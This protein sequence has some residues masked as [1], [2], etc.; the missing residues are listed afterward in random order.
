[1]RYMKK[2]S[3]FFFL[4]SFSSLLYAQ[5]SPQSSTSD[6]L[7]TVRLNTLKYGTETEIANLVQTLKNEGVDY[8]D[9]EIIALVENTRNQKILGGAFAFFSEREKS[10]LE[11]RAARA[12]EERDDEKNETILAAIDY[13]GRVKAADAVPIL[14]KIIEGG[15]KRFVN[16]AIRAFGR[17]SGA[18]GRS[19]RSET[20]E[21]LIDFYQNRSPDDDSR[22]EIITAL[23][24]AGSTE[25]AEFLSGIAIDG[26]EKMTLRIAALESIAKIGDSAGL[27]AVLACVSAADANIRSAAVAALGP[28]S[29]PAA[30]EAILDAFRDSYYRTRIAAAQASRQRKLAAAVPYLKF[31][32]ERDEVPTVKEEAVRAL[33]SIADSES[34]RILESFFT[35]RKT[36]E[37]VRIVSGEMLMQIQPDRFLDSLVRE[38]DEAKQKNQNSLYN[39]ILKIIGGAKCSN[40]EAITRRLMETNGAVEKSTALDM[41][42]NNN[43]TSLAAEIKT[44][45]E[46]KSESLAAKARRTLEKLGVGN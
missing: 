23:G 18:E 35:E 43:L 4:F 7:E 39:G 8:L 22:R 11:S 6:S 28:F 14:Q 46:G 29:G 45:A 10:G 17:I 3:F 2:I 5:E 40:M 27:D 41:A 12:I 42:A 20:T 13:L 32:A 33:G 36:N 38:M 21:Y 26:D 34:V 15:E 30:E 37:R 1:M 24:A 44:I 31:R 16:A 19:S 9:N 25:A